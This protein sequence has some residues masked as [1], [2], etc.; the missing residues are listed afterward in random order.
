MKFFL[1]LVVSIFSFGL[2]Y[3]QV[4]IHQE[5]FELAPAGVGTN[6]EAAVEFGTSDVNDY[7]HRVLVSGNGKD[8]LNAGVSGADGTY[9]YA[10]ED[11][12]DRELT[13]KNISV[14]GYTN[15]KVKLSVGSGQ[16]NKYDSDDFIKVFVK[17]NNG[18]EELIGAFYGY[19]HS[20]GDNSNGRMYHDINLNGTTSDSSSVILSEAL[21]EFSFDVTGVISTLQVIVKMNTNYG[22]EVLIVDNIIIEGVSASTDTELNFAS[23]TYLSSENGT[24]IVLCVDI[25]N[26]SATATIADIVLTSTSAPHVTYSTTGITFPSSSSV[27][28]CVTVTI[29]DNAVCGDATDYTFEIQNV[30]GGTNTSAGS[31]NQS[32]LSISDDDA[33][34]GVAAYQGF[35]GVGTY[36]FTASPVSYTASGDIWGITTNYG[37]ISGPSAG[38]NFWAG[39]DLQNGNG[40][41]T[42]DHTL[43]FDNYI[44]SSL[45]NASISFNYNAQGFNTSGD[46]SVVLTNSLG[47]DSI[48]NLNLTI[49]SNTGILNMN[50]T[51]KKLI[52]RLDLLGQE[53]PIR[54]NTPMF[55][56]YDDGTV[57]KKIIIE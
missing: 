10:G 35:E 37:A 2:G 4:I 24:S 3:G 55:Y 14:L 9:M 26:E 49:I 41:G 38:S 22:D 20:N 32:I 34:S 51:E 28:Q 1:V 19:D 46:Y 47:C 13:L 45:D 50:N 5:S 48:V 44:T 36:G 54:K 57:E 53:T 11:F 42:F 25:T 18:A 16:Q 30:N 31:T 29:A 52:N 8:E 40:G 33:I 39:D 6:Y 12:D 15:I 7:W 27:Q 43:T 23:A 17:K 21:S 56:I